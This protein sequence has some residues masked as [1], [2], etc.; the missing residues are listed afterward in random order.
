ML[1]YD[2]LNLTLINIHRIGECRKILLASQLGFSPFFSIGF[3][4]PQ[5][6]L[7]RF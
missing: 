2:V 6:S 5:L 3:G 7:A 1:N 4:G